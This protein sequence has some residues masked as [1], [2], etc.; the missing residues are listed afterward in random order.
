MRSWPAAAMR[1]VLA[2]VLAPAALRAADVELTPQIGGVVGG[3]TAT[4]Q[5]D[6]ELDPGAA[7]GLTVGWWVRHDGLIELTYSRQDTAIELDS[8]PLF[9]ATLDYLHA[10]GAWEIETGP[11]RPFIGL[12]LGAARVDPASGSLDSAWF[13]SAGM[14]GGVKRYFNDRVGL[15]VEGRGLLHLVT[16]G[17]DVFCAGGGGAAGCAA[18]ISGSGFF[19]LQ[20]TAG[21]IIR[22]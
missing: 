6:L 16:S 12:G 22:L 2:I 15:R 13:F 5:G 4:R 8:Q 20:A 17:G 19:Q 11:T 7:V 18:S 9:D 14:Y 10:G 3:V 21:L 1:L